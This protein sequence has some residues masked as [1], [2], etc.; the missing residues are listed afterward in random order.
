[1]RRAFADRQ[2]RLPALLYL[3]DAQQPV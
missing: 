1:M 2:K 3:I